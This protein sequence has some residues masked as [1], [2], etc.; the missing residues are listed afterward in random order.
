[1]TTPPGTTKRSTPKAPNTIVVI[2][3]HPYP[4]RSRAGRALLEAVE[5]LPDVEIRSLYDRYPDFAI[6]VA[7]EQLA[8][9]EAAVVAWQCP[10]YWYGIPALLTLWFEKVLTHGFAHGEGGDALRGKPLQWVTTT[11]TPI[12]AYRAAGMHHHDFEAFIPPIEETARFCGMRWE[13]PLVVHAAHQID[14]ATLADHA[15]D[16]R[17]RLETLAREARHG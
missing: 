17:A 14:D 5:S 1:V 3:A 13:K 2:H 11:G 6:D 16:Y 15:K 8:L 9:R 12:S 10:F 4:R 7:S